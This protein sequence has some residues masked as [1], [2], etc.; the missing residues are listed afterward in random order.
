M[1]NP[2]LVII[3]ATTPDDMDP[4][5]RADLLQRTRDML[6]AGFYQVVG[7]RSVAGILETEDIDAW[8]AQLPLAPWAEVEVTALRQR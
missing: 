7:Q 6:P 8:V 1:S 2:Y 4:E 3:R 5:V